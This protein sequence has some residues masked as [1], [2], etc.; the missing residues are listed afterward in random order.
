MPG[1]QP[2]SGTSAA[3]PTLAAVGTLVRSAKPSLP[4]DTV[5]AILEQRGGNVDCTSAAGLPDLDCGFGLPFADTAVLAALDTTPPAVTAALGPAAPTGQNGFYTGD[6]TVGWTAS[7]PQS[8]ISGLSGCD[9][10]TVRPTAR[11]R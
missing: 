4:V 10:A 1:F 2:F 6:V 8:P 3:T 7:D 9:P 11:R 5:E